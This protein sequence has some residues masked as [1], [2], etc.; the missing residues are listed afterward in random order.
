MNFDETK[1]KEIAA[2][3]LKKLSLDAVGAHQLFDAKNLTSLTFGLNEETRSQ[4]LRLDESGPLRRLMIVPNDYLARCRELAV[5]FPN[6]AGY[7]NDFLLPALALAHIRKA[8]LQLPPTV[9]VGSP[10]VGKTL[11][12][13]TLAEVFHLDFERINLETSQAS[14]ELVGTARGWSNAQP[15]LLFRWMVRSEFANGVFVD[16]NLRFH[17]LMQAYSRTNRI[18]DAT[19]TF[20]NIVTFRDLEQATIDAI[21]LFGDKNTKNVVL[22]K[23]YKEYMEGFTDLATGEARRGFVDV[24]KELE[25]RF[26][27]PAAIEKEVDKKDFA[28][29]FGEYLR[30]EN[31]LQNYDEFASLKALQSVDVSDPAAVEEFKAQHY[32]N[33]ADLAALQAITLPPDRKIQDYRSTYND[34]RDWLRKQKTADEKDKSTVDWDDVVFE[35]DLLKSQE[36]NLDYILELIFDHNKKN[37]T[38]ADLVDE[39]RRVIR[40]SLGNRAKESLL[41]DFINQTD[42]D[43]IGDKASVIEAHHAGLGIDGVTEAP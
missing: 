39:V 8:S 10:G 19:K 35:V 9:F 13:S 42:L 21:T 30:I 6:F 34:V 22:E 37:K 31:V 11:F 16:K 33:D 15:G 38:K 23:S 3:K 40:A 25:T 18:F 36:I 14:L 27:D 4:L 26:P 2:A 17:G 41:V 1:R 29:L 43:Q 28:K 24:V 7:I 20:G 5:R 12:V 32:L